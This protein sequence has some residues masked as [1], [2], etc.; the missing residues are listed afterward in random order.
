METKICRKCG[1]ELPTENFYKNHTC[2]DGFDTICKDCKNAYQKEWQKKNK[3]KKNAQKIANER[4]EFE[5][6][7]KIYTCKE[8]A[9][10]TPRE[11]MLELK[12]RGYE[13]ELLYI[14]HIVKEHRINLGKLE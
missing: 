2:K 12:A 7:Y 1:R 4:V 14:E 11:L 5:K 10:F 6:K 9:P 13:G 8:L 3:E